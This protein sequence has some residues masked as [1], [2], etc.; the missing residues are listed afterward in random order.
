[1]LVLEASPF[2]LE[3]HWCVGFWDSVLQLPCIDSQSVPLYWLLQRRSILQ[4][5]STLL[6][7]GV[8]MAQHIP[9]LLL[10]ATEVDTGAFLCRIRCIQRLPTMLLSLLS[11]IMFVEIPGKEMSMAVY[12]QCREHA[13][14]KLIKLFNAGHEWQGCKSQIP[15]LGMK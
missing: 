15:G 11:M 14:V 1:M 12:D 5:L 13:T 9:S 3:Q 4:R 8:S 10:R 7:L 2:Q 6:R